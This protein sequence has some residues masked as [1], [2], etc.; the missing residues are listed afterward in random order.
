MSRRCRARTPATQC[1]ALGVVQVTCLDFFAFDLAGVEL[2]QRVGR[3]GT[4]H[5]HVGGK[6]VDVDLAHLITGQT[7]FG[8]QGTHDVPGSN[9]LFAPAC[10]LQSH[11]RGQGHA[12]WRR[13]QRGQRHPLGLPALHLLNAPD[14]AHLV[15][16]DQ[17]NRQALRR[18]ASGASDSVHVHL[19]VWSHVHVDHRVN[20]T[21]VQTA[22]GHVGG[23]QDRATAVGELNQHLIALALVQIT[24]QSQRLH[25]L[26]LQHCHQ[27]AALLLGVA[28][29]QAAAGL[30]VR[31]NLPHRM[32]AFALIDLDHQ[33]ANLLSAVLAGDLHHLGLAHEALGLGAPARQVRRKV[34]R[35]ED[36]GQ[37]HELVREHAAADDVRVAVIELGDRGG[38]AWADAVVDRLGH[39]A[40]RAGVVV[41][42]KVAAHL[43]VGITQTLRVLGRGGVEQQVKLCNFHHH[44]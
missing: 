9:L 26:R 38:D 40:D 17:R 30:E 36:D 16:A 4:R 33:L 18:C 21:H 22:R 23:H 1:S 3:V 37:H 12:A 35:P 42:L 31:Q 7:R 6:V 24:I 44:K 34:A 43:V 28:K 14:V 29:G 5:R 11:H 15:H 41:A 8:T 13:G 27:I 20:V 25:A 32:Q 39:Q 2:G 10:Q 19:G